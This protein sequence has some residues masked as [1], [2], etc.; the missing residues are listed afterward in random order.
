MTAPALPK[1]FMSLGGGEADDDEATASGF[2]N[3]DEFA[4]REKLKVPDFW[5]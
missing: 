4:F 2:N 3:T 5:L 1:A